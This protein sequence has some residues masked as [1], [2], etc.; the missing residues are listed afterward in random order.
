[1]TNGMMRG[2]VMSYVDDLFVTGP[3]YVVEA[4]KAKF[5]ETWATSKPEYVGEHPVRFLG[6]EVKKE[7]KAEDEREV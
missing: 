1:M 3:S 5:E 4:V 2:L 6:M 7:R